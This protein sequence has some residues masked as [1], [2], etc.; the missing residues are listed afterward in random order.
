MKN[1]FFWDVTPCASCKNRRF[2]EERR[3]TRIDELGTLAVTSNRRTLI[4]LVITTVVRTSDLT[5]Y[6]FFVSDA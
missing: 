1:A 2:G 5:K 3:V 6:R 4:E